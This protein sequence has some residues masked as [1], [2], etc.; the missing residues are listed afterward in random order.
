MMAGYFILE[1]QR[2]LQE[3]GYAFSDDSLRTFI[4]V[5]NMGKLS[6]SRLK[7]REKMYRFFLYA[8]KERRLPHGDR[9]KDENGLYLLYEQDTQAII[10]LMERKSQPDI[11]NK[12]GWDKARELWCLIYIYGCLS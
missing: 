5:H 7:D 11:D 9:D 12:S 1:F 8:I 4:S 10:E 2:Y 3:E 6:A